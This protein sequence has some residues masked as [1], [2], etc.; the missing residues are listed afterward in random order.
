MIVK[1]KIKVVQGNGTTNLL[2]QPTRGARV[3]GFLLGCTYSG[4]TNT[5]AAL[6]TALTNVVAKR[7]NVRK[8]ELT[9]TQLNDFLLLHGQGFTGLPNTK[10]MVQIPFAPR[11]MFDSVASALAWN[12][13]DGQGDISVEITSSTALTVVA[14][15]LIDFD[16]NAPS[17]GMLTL[18]VINPSVG[19]VQSVIEQPV[20][21]AVGDAVQISVYPDSGASNEITPCGF[22][23]G[24]DN[25]YAHENLTSTENDEELESYGKTPA[26]SG[27]TANI[28]DLLFV[29]K[30][31]LTQ[32][33]PLRGGCK[34]DIQAGSSMSGTSKVLIAR[35]E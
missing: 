23:Y 34:L 18:E 1:R 8:W 11:W 22:M 28:Y 6:A 4:G 2:I 14:Y 33:I 10:T 24:R 32:A 3:H 35:I 29:T 15:E 12:P 27:R 19:G 16:L 25:Q 13:A 9:G 7:G 17:A 31:D 26:A 30:S 21:R 20:I 5:A